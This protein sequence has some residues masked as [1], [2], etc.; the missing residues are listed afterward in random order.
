MAKILLIDDD[1]ELAESLQIWLK[2]VGHMAE[3]ALSGEDALQM[4]R[5]YQYDVVVLDWVLPAMSGLEVCLEY[6]RSGGT[7]PIIFLTGQGAVDQ[8]EGG[9]DA[10]ADDY[11]V[12]PFEFRVLAARIRSL[13]RRPPRLLPI[14]LVVNGITLDCQER[15]ISVDG[16][17]FHLRPKESSLLEYMMRHPDVHCSSQELLD[18]VWPSDTSAS[19][20]TIRTWMRNL[21]K[22]LAKAGKED[23]IKTTLGSGYVIES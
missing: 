4:L 8:V 17:E 21:R 11:L 22:T 19:P 13:L 9:L 18:A 6:R 14:E 5:C 16:K 20:D 10:G 12:K 3:H 7:T 23:F 2:T 1:L 15:T